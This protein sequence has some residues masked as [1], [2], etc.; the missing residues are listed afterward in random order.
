M[1]SRKNLFLFPT[2]NGQ[3]DLVKILYPLAKIPDQNEALEECN[4]CERPDRNMGVTWCRYAV[5]CGQLEVLKTLTELGDDPFAPHH[6]HY[7]SLIHLVTYDPNPSM[8][9]VLIPL[10]KNANAPD[11]TDT[12]PMHN[13]VMKSNLECVK[14]LLPSATQNLDVQDITGLTPIEYAYKNGSTEIFELLLP[15]YQETSTLKKVLQRSVKDGNIDIVKKLIAHC[16]DQ[17]IE[18]YHSQTPIDNAL[19]QGN[20]EMLELLVPLCSKTKLQRSLHSAAKNGKIGSVQMLAPYFDDLTCPDE[21]GITPIHV[22]TGA[23]F[24]NN[25]WT[26]L[27]HC[28]YL[29]KILYLLNRKED[30]EFN[31]SF[32]TALDEIKNAENLQLCLKLIAPLIKDPN[33]PDNK[34]QTPIHIAA[35]KGRLQRLNIFMEICE[36]E[37]INPPDHAGN[38]P[39][40]L[41]AKKSDND[42]IVKIFAPLCTNLNHQNDQGLTALHVAVNENN[43][44]IV[45]TL[46]PLYDDPNAPNEN[47]QSPI[48]TAVK[49]LIAL[50]DEKKNKSKKPKI[51]A[52][53]MADLMEIFRILASNCDNP[54]PPDAQGNTPLHLAAQN[55]LVEVVKVLVPF[56]NNLDH[57][58]KEG[59]TAWQVAKTNKHARIAKMLAPYGGAEKKSRKTKAPID[60]PKPASKKAKIEAPKNVEPTSKPEH[61]QNVQPSTSGS[62]QVSGKGKSSSKHPSKNAK[63]IEPEPETEQ[64]QEPVAEV[65]NQVIVEE[66]PKPKPK[67]T[68]RM[69]RKRLN[70]NPDV[71]QG[72]SSSKIAKVD[73]ETCKNTIEGKVEKPKPKRT[74][75][76]KRRI[77]SKPTN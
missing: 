55:G 71:D 4:Y 36:S 73:N 58:N 3:S 14:L 75:R 32:L 37:N 69:K 15:H 60:A 29:L 66:K 13:A 17:D 10:A 54:N 7:R 21:N 5:K 11:S 8:L 44:D 1:I 77:S 25:F 43:I 33:V 9:E 62:N 19:R 38:T 20:T 26:E 27:E 41:L 72:E 59:N 34:G 49:M 53:I 65:E 30:C 46:I 35:N 12:T 68:R 48:H 18:D 23:T 31:E 28:A 47:G 42:H 61:D 52:E 6:A 67:R 63:P 64:N 56:Q 57:K 76:L 24:L 39:L 50:K 40:H 2:E 45:K 70:E 22:A 74:R 16:K 51:C